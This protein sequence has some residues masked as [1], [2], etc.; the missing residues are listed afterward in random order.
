M[1]A[2]IETGEAAA[3]RPREQ[4]LRVVFK[5]LKGDMYVVGRM[6]NDPLIAS[7]DYPLHS[8][9]RRPFLLGFYEEPA[10]TS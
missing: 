2:V 7:A 3:A 9:D 8:T 4:C 6:M 10:C 5:N 1:S